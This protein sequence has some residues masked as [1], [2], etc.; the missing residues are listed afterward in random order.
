VQKNHRIEQ[1]KAALV[2]AQA[3]ESQ[4]TSN[5]TNFVTPHQDEFSY[6]RGSRML[7]AEL[8]ELESPGRGFIRKTEMR[9]TKRSHN[10]QDTAWIFS[11]QAHH[12][13]MPS[14]HRPNSVRQQKFG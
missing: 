11:R 6:L 10:M 1:L 9:N 12:Q 13:D 4:T 2:L 5:A 7:K 3:N 8:E 14:R